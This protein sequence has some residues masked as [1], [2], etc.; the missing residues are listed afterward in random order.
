MP[1]TRDAVQ[2]PEG[3]EGLARVY[4][5]IGDFDAAVEQLACPLPSADA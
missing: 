4:V 1:V 3:I 5:M 2:G